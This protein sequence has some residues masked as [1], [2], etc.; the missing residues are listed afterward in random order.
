[1]KYVNAERKIMPVF[2]AVLMT[3][4][5]TS[6]NTLKHQTQHNPFQ[7]FSAKDIDRVSICFEERIYGPQGRATFDPDNRPIDSVIPVDFYLKPSGA[8]IRDRKTIKQ[9]HSALRS[10][11]I[12]T[13]YPKTASGIL[14]YQVFFDKENK[15]LAVTSI[16]NYQCNVSFRN[17][18]MQN[19][20]IHFKEM[21][22]Q[23]CQNVPFCKAIYEFMN[24]EL[25][26]TIAYWEEFFKDHGGHKKHLFEGI[27]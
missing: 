15:I 27:E 18:A 26:E 21:T 25:P 19:G 8:A 13:G 24:K 5:V 23:G 7:E 1:M 17:C 16:E 3:I 14:S 6:C 20:W 2:V 12:G 22:F 10:S 9:L 4:V 11:S